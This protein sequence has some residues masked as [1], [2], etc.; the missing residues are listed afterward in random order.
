VKTVSGEA[1]RRFGESKHR[2]HPDEVHIIETEKGQIDF[3]LEASDL[4]YP[5]HFNTELIA[6]F[7]ASVK[8]ASEWGEHSDTEVL[9]LRRLGVATARGFKPN[10]ACALLFA[11]DPLVVF[12][13]CKIRF[14]RYEGEYEQTGA[15]FNAVKDITIEGPIP[16]LITTIEGV[17]DAQLRTFSR[18]GSDGKFYTAPEYPKP[19][20]YEAIVNACVHRSYSI[21]NMNIFVKMFND[22]LVVESPGGF[23]PFVSPA[24]IY[25]CSHPRNP[26]IMSA[27]FHL[28][29][30]KAANE[31]TR[32]MRDTMSKMNL[33]TPE[34]A[35]KD[36]GFNTQVRVTLRNS[37]KQRREWIDSDVSAIVGDT[38]ASL[39]T[40]EERMAVNRIAEHG[41]ITVSEFARLAGRAWHSAKRVLEDMASREII[42]QK[43]RTFLDRDPQAKYFLK[44]KSDTR[45]KS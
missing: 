25:E 32:R 44:K 31:G 20:W 24:N 29:F 42:E 28:H 39:L 16:L 37:V 22:R 15:E 35:E 27:M 6:Q 14:F 12:P 1:F 5:D 36:T 26:H 19:A 43:K 13:G 21:R 30:V 7:A 3:E 38:I 8:K 2:L 18:L 40:E 10:N 34:F 23:P 33:P 45:K 9:K 4:K 41:H 17:L 11:K